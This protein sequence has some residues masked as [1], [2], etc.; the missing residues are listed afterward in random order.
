MISND[1]LLIDKEIKSKLLEEQNNR[2]K[3][4]SQIQKNP[5]KTQEII[6]LEKTLSDNN[7]N[8]KLNFYLANTLELLKNYEML[9]KEP[10]V[11][12]FMGKTNNSN[13]D[14]K[15]QEIIN[16]YLNI[17][18]DFYNDIYK[19]DIKNNKY[20]CVNCEN[21][22]MFTV[23]NNELFICEICFSQ[24]IR[25]ID[26]SSY[27]DIERINISTKY[28]YDR[29][30]HFKECINNY[31]GKISGVVP[32][33]LFKDLE[34]KFIFHNLLV[35]HE[36]KKEKYKNISKRNIMSF[37]KELSYSKYY[38]NLNYIYSQVTGVKPKD[39]SHLTRLLLI[40]FDILS[41]L[42]DKKF[43]NLNR[44][45]FINTQYVLF[46][47]LKKHDFHCSKED[48]VTIKTN[49]RKVFHEHIIKTLFEE[50]GWNYTSIF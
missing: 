32:V 46:Q 11:I 26:V 38:E 22:S 3:L 7:I 35:D 43:K 47:L 18:S 16:K 8:N 48:F 39:I 21:D 41:D 9:L 45:N 31:Q 28:V 40:D 44:K 33:K 4:L 23:I 25:K 2:E 20:K 6:R 37:L 13:Q 27:N 24:Q 19:D 36:D 29:K 30:S 5:I 17:A 34:D 42:Y 1:I 10:T 15:K 12:S 50:L 14:I 49:E